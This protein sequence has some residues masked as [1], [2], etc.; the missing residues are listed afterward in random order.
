MQYVVMI[1]MLAFVTILV[2]TTG[3]VDSIIITLEE[4]A[5]KQM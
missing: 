2:Y 4:K 3:D 1:Q 5:L